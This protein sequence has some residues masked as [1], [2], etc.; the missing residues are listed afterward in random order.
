[1]LGLKAC[2]P[3]VVLRVGVLLWN[4]TSSDTLRICV[5]FYL[6]C[7]YLHSLLILKSSQIQ[8]SLVIWGL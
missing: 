5:L 1:V 2:A 6:D 4:N 3:S 7:V 8:S